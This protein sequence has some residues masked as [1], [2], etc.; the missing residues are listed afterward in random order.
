MKENC[1]CIKNYINADRSSEDFTRYRNELIKEINDPGILDRSSILADNAP[2]KKE[3][4]IVI[5]AFESVTN[6]ME[7]PEALENL[8]KLDDSSVLASWKYI[9][10]AIKAFYSHNYKSM[11]DFLENIEENTPPKK[12]GIMLLHL[13][14]LKEIPSPDRIQ[15]KFISQIQQDRSILLSAR[16]QI[17]DALSSGM[18]E[19]FIET[20]ILFV[21]EMKSR[22]PEA[23]EKLA[24]W[25]IRQASMR[26]F[27]QS[28]FLSSYK[29]IFGKVKG[30]RLFA[31]AL[32]DTEPDISILFWLQSLI[33]QLRQGDA[34]R[35][36][37]AAY[38]QIISQEI[39][40]SL[41]QGYIEEEEKYFID[42][43]TS[44][45]LRLHQE[46]ILYFPSFISEKQGTDPFDLFFKLK[47]E[48][49]GDIFTVY[50]G[51]RFNTKNRI[52]TGETQVDN[53]IRKKAP[54]QLSLF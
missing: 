7:N 31:L 51:T 9:T 54:L 2:L 37:A 22:Y 18:E 20:T 43:F 13:S 39:D 30:L 24:L 12:L 27:S 33:A 26:D 36:M 38:M 53:S 8:Y 32:K 10:L 35:D 23:A 48:I 41:A 5:D 46:C 6:G 25:S 50:S 45:V 52:K 49:A 11:L 19:L 4:Q 47:N 29:M 1:L 3:A 28:L 40:F 42:G 34:S 17:A 14:G 15:K 16:E 21:R 44:L